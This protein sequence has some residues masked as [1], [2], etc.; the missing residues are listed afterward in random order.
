MSEL[1]DLLELLHGARSRYRTVR[2]EAREWRHNHR[3]LE[4]YERSIRAVRGSAI[5][6]N[7]GDPAE[8]PAESEVETR[9]WFEPPNRLREERLEAGRLCTAVANGERWWTSMPEWATVVQDGD[10]WATGSVGQTAQGLLDPGLL[11]G[12]L[13]LEL[14]GRAEAAGREALVV[15][16]APRP[17]PHHAGVEPL[18]HGATRHELL[19]DAERG[20]LLSLT[21]YLDDQPF[22][23]VRVREIAFDE[24]IDGSV[25]TYEAAEGEE[26]L[27]PHDVSPGEH[28]SI[29]EAARRATFTVL[30]PRSLGRGWR[31]HVLSTPGRERPP[32]RETV[33]VSLFRDDAT[34]TVSIRQTPPPF[35]TWQRNGTERV[36]RDG[37]VLWVADTGWRRVLLEREGTCVEV[38]SETI[39]AEELVE[40]ALSL[41]PSPTERPPLLG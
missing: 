9:I 4:A 18:S 19:V 8:A 20:V 31:M 2:L 16:A 5:Q 26:V 3:L 10:G 34:H 29:E 37:R 41:E 13:E 23:V 22:S 25:F 24:A 39:E 28:V 17:S 1:G 40:L 38:G 30:V 11:L 32:M 36:E 21:A 7:L 27:G 33:H 15:A 35:E 12:V 6:V 14:R